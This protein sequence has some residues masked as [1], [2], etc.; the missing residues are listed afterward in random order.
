MMTPDPN[1]AFLVTSGG[2]HSDPTDLTLYAMQ[3]LTGDQ[4]AILADHLSRCTE[5]RA[6]L[7]RIQGDLALAALAADLETPSAAARQ[8]LLDQVAREKK[9]VLVAATP[10]SQTAP[11][12]ESAPQPQLRPVAT[13]GSSNLLLAGRERKP[14][15]RSRLI[16]LTGL[17]WAAAAALCLVSGLLLRDRQNLRTNLAAQDNEIARLDVDAASAHQLMDALTDPAAM[18]VS[19]RV[20]ATPKPA[21]VPSGGV[22]YNP[23]KGTL[24]FLASNLG[25]IEQY[26]A[27]ELWIIPADNSAPIPAGTFHPDQQ[28]NA[29]V[30]MPDL[31]KGIPAKAFGVTLEPDGGSQTPTMPLVMFGN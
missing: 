28:G 2:A 9:A 14:K 25:A 16:V 15:R 12:T 31:P 18:R 1:T 26:K 19:M 30:V 23:R 29:S 22:T 24:I 21:G 5:C 20:P 8:R 3:L 11:A 17:G 27:Y 10:P 4:A 7:A 13:F 6:E